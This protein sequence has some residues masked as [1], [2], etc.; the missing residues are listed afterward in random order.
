[1]SQ[2]MRGKSFVV[3]VA[4]VCLFVGITAGFFA[5]HRMMDDMSG[6]TS[7]GEMKGHG[8][9]GMKGMAGMGDMKEMPMEGAKSM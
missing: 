3:G 7:G 8:M 6:M 2:D 4:V 9:E 5:A 1:M